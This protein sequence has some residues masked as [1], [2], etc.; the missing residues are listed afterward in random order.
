MDKPII[1][2]LITDLKHV[3]TINEQAAITGISR[4]QLNRIIAGDMPYW[5][6]GWEIYSLHES[7]K[8]KIRKAKATK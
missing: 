8:T 1:G 5:H 6:N 2:E 4:S 7:S 3:Y